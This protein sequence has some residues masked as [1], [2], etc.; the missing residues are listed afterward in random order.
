MQ[1]AVAHAAIPL[2][3]RKKRPQAGDP[4]DPP[5]GFV[6]NERGAL[7]RVEEADRATVLVRWARAVAASLFRMSSAAF[8]LFFFFFPLLS[9]PFSFYIRLLLVQGA[10]LLLISSNFW[11]QTLVKS[12]L[13]NWSLSFLTGQILV[14][15]M[16]A[17]WFERWSTLGLTRWS[18]QLLHA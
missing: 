10:L 11:L 18:H 3:P 16:A 4:A 13:A 8:F 12:L 1:E 9:L 15:K 5:A 7:V 17:L 6:L 14:I 2:P